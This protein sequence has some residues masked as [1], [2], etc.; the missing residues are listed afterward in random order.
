MRN[1]PEVTYLEQGLHDTPDEL[2]RRVQQA[3]DALEAKGETVIFLAYGLCGRGLTGVT[4]HTATLILPRVHD[5]IGPA[6]GGRT[7]QRS[8]LGGA[9]VSPASLLANLVHPKAHKEYERFG[10]DSA[11][12]LIELEGSGSETIPT[13]A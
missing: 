3:V 10:T 12:Y 13:P 4:G 6:R 8:S 2:R 5:C 1:A 11:A 9:L 7:S